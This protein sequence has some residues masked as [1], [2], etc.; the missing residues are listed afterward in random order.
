MY[1]LSGTIIAVILLILKMALFWVNIDSRQFSNF[2]NSS[3]M[4]YGI[5]LQLVTILLISIIFTVI[6]LRKYEQK[7]ALLET[8]NEIDDE[9][10][11]VFHAKLLQNE[12]KKYAELKFLESILISF[13][14]LRSIFNVMLFSGIVLM[15]VLCLT[16]Y[17]LSALSVDIKT[18]S[19]IGLSVFVANLS[20]LSMDNQL[21]SNQVFVLSRYSVIN[22]IL[23]QLLR[24]STETKQRN[25]II[26]DDRLH[27]KEFQY[28]KYRN[29]FQS[30]NILLRDQLEISTIAKTEIMRQKRVDLSNQKKKLE[31]SHNSTS[32]SMF[33]APKILI[34]K[35]TQVYSPH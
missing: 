1:D 29:N 16:F 13:I 12:M 28:T 33:S 10:V 19:Y 23:L 22:N 25:V 32:M 18:I 8:Y 20:I 35:K 15:T 34:D 17:L 21:N 31:E 3:M 11:D 6:G 26:G 5:W 7:W 30:K 9:F 2:T 4:N 14:I 27:Q 24:D